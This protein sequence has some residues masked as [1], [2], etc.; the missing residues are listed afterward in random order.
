MIV[1]E[2]VDNR[3]GSIDNGDFVFFPYALLSSGSSGSSGSA[4]G[5][6]FRSITTEELRDILANGGGQIGYSTGSSGSSG[7]S[8]CNQAGIGF[9]FAPSGRYQRRFQVI[10][11]GCEELLNA[12]SARDALGIPRLGDP[13]PTDFY[14]LV[15][16]KSAESEPESPWI[17]Y[18]TVNYSR[19]GNPLLDPWKID[20]DFTTFTVAAVKDR[21]GNVIRNSAK[22]RFDP[23]PEIEERR[24]TLSL[25]RNVYD[26]SLALGLSYSN[27]VN[28]G[29]IRIA[30]ITF[31]EGK[32][33]CNAWK[34]SSFEYLGRRYWRETIVVE[35]NESGWKLRVADVGFADINGVPFRAQGFVGSFAAPLNPDGSFRNPGQDVLSK[36]FEVYTPRDFC[37]LNLD[38]GVFA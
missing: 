37:L 29:P 12:K 2:R 31:A 32:L 13:F 17:W 21:F 36:E 7:S 22:Q 18:V 35:Y 24:F 27:A 23:V 28:D 38:Y 6:T 26:W 8:G 3:S 15:V 11:E 14:S 19:E 34:A 5:T 1:Q 20:W 9:L 25:S 16:S 30:G 4:P 10:S 33:K